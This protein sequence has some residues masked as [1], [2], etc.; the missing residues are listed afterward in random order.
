MTVAD[1]AD[2]EANCWL[3][4]I[5]LY[6]TEIKFRSGYVCLSYDC[7]LDGLVSNH[8]D[9]FDG[10]LGLLKGIKAHVELVDGAK[11]VCTKPYLV[12]NALRPKVEL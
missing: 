7:Q 9:L 10:Q 3:E 5:K 1:I 4:A 11:P 8:Q 2:S 6:W 12:P